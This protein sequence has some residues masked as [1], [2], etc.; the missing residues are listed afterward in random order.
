MSNSDKGLA[1]G[2][3]VIL[4][5]LLFILS[6]AIDTAIVALVWNTF[7]LRNVFNAGP[8]SFWGCVGIGFIITFF[9]GGSRVSVNH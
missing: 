4:G 2:V 8:F 7:G 5:I 1:I 9:F 6:L 3:I